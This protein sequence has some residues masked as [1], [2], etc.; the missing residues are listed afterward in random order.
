MIDLHDLRLDDARA[1]L[2]HDATG[3]LPEPDESRTQYLQRVIDQLCELSLKDP[4]TGLANRRHFRHVLGREIDAVARSGESAL[5]LMMDIDHFKK[6]NDTYGHLAGDRVLQAVAKALASCVRP[7]DTVARYGG[8]EFTAVLP[9]CPPSFGKIVAE[10]IRATVGSLQVLVA[11]LVS[12]QVTISIG[13]AFAPEWVR[14]TT[15]LWIDRADT[16]LYRA[17][18]EGRNR[19]YIDRQPEIAVS[20]EEKKMLFGHLSIGD[21]AWLESVSTDASVSAADSAMNR[22]N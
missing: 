15:A 5:L 17:K 4:L 1:L 12:L 11:P 13:G 2:E 18:S 21:P 6:V 8:E 20:S 3:S 16:Q 22:V 9:N 10:R 19:V 14:S 7:M